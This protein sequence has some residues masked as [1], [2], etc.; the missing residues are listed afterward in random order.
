MILAYHVVI[1]A[2][3]FW[4]PN[5]PRG[6]WSD[7][8]RRWELLRFGPATKVS[9]GR[10]RA[11]DEHDQAL[12]QAA[13]RALQFPPVVFDGHQALAVSRGF[14]QA[15]EE[16]GYLI[17]ECSILPEHIHLVVGRHERHVERIA[18]HLKTRAHQ[19]L[20]KEGLWFKDNRPVW[21]RNCWKVY[22]DSVEGVRK[23]IEYVKQNPV[24]EGKKPQKWSFMS[25][26]LA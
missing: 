18:G 19:S 4:L 3:G 13:K 5:D 25:P 26:Y 16:S 24:R 9:D 11:R 17:H 23:A 14:A 7:F 1:S 2:Y 20:K 21:G 6:S 15:C 22:L 8:V 12:R 10:S